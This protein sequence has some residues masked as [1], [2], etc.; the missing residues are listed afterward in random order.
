VFLDWLLQTDIMFGHFK[1]PI[2]YLYV[3]V[4]LVSIGIL[5]NLV[6]LFVPSPK[7]VTTTES[8][9]PQRQGLKRRLL[10]IGLSIVFI[11]I[12]SLVILISVL[13]ISES[14]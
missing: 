4:P 1:G 10:G 13:E 6:V 12:S 14:R 2:W 5:L 7:P 8:T 3:T 9:R 11:L